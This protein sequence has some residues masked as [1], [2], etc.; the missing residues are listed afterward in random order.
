M[1]RQIFGDAS[2]QTS[3]LI[4]TVFHKWMDGSLGT[5]WLNADEISMEELNKADLIED[6]PLMDQW[7]IS[8]L[9]SL[10]KTVNEKMENYYYL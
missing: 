1:K 3:A 9:Q 4:L 8:T 10:I 5:L 7:I 6:R 2:G